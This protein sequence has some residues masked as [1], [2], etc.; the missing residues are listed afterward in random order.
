MHTGNIKLQA[1]NY[2]SVDGMGLLVTVIGG[3]Q[4]SDNDIGATWLR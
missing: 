4:S 2:N 3:N 1:K